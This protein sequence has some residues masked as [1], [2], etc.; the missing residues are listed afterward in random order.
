MSTDHQ[1][2]LAIAGHEADR[3][4]MYYVVRSSAPAQAMALGG[5]GAVAE[6]FERLAALDGALIET[7]AGP[8]ALCL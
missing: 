4:A 5:A 3:W 2:T 7:E 8:T 6:R 1:T